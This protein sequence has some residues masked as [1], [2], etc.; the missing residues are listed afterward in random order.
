[1]DITIVNTSSAVEKVCT[2][3]DFA[4][5]GAW[6]LLRYPGA[7]LW[8][9]SLRHGGM[10]CKRHEHPSW[11]LVPADLEKLRAMAREREI[12]ISVPR[13]AVARPKKPQ[14]PVA[15]KQTELFR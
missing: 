14:Q 6:A 11:R 9:F 3:D 10:E 8:A 5:K 1:M 2:F 12:K 4:P 15:Q 7:G 13:R